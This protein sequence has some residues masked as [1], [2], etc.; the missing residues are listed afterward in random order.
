MKDKGW[1]SL[2][3]LS[4]LVIIM[5]IVPM[6]SGAQ[7]PHPRPPFDWDINPEQLERLRALLPYYLLVKTIFATLGSILLLSL[8][9]IYFGIY[10]KT[11][12]RFSLGLIIFSAA[13]LLYT[14]SSNPLIHRF[15]GFRRIGLGP[16]LMIPDLFTCIASAIL[17]YLSRQ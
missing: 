4:I 17:L 12:T 8:L 10:R 13:L 3:L 5:F 1:L 15:V 9:L 7:P 2:A 14:I 6:A 16:L 11:G